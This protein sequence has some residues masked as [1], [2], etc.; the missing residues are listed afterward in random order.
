MKRDWYQDVNSVFL[1]IWLEVD[2]HL[3]PCHLLKGL[4]RA[5]VEWIS[6]LLSV[7]SYGIDSGKGE[8]GTRLG[9]PHA[10]VLQLGP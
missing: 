10:A 5:C 6:L 4:M 2:V 8:I 9:H 1:S 7:G 3:F